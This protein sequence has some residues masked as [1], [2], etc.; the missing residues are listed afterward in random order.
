[1]LR[2]LI[3]AGLVAT[4]L[5]TAGGW[6]YRGDWWAMQLVGQSHPQFVEEPSKGPTRGI[7][8]FVGTQVDA[9]TQT[10]QLRKSWADYAHVVVPVFS[11]E[12]F[13]RETIIEDTFNR[14]R[15]QGLHEL[16]LIG[17]SGGG[18][19]VVEFMRYNRAHGNYFSISGVIIEDAPMDQTDLVDTRAST[20]EEWR[21]GLV[22]NKLSSL[23]WWVFGGK[24]PP[25]AADADLALLA[26]H[27]SISKSY[28]LSGWGDQIRAILRFIPVQPGEFTGVPFVYLMSVPHEGATDDGVVKHSSAPKWVAGFGE[29]DTSIMRVPSP[30]A[31]WVAFPTVWREV[32]GSTLVRF[33]PHG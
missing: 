31:E 16:C 8:A 18:Q 10:H 4:V 22:Q 12:I 19:M 33:Y 11:Q 30:H 14:L 2:K 3:L 27:H 17:S 23:F 21:P 1:M 20:M 15:D 7:A 13:D 5:L 25:P 9:E 26:E 24:A 6:V 28:K 29:T 32:F